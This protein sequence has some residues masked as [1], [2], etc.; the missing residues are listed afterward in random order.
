MWNCCCSVCELCF[1]SPFA[2]HPFNGSHAWFTAPCIVWLSKSQPDGF[3]RQKCKQNFFSR[4]QAHHNSNT[5][6]KF[7]PSMLLLRT[8]PYVASNPTSLNRQ[9]FVFHLRTSA[10]FVF[11]GA[12]SS[13]RALS[14]VLCLNIHSRTKTLPPISCSSIPLFSRH[15]A[16][17]L[18]ASP[19]LTCI[20][21]HVISTLKLFISPTPVFYLAQ[22]LRTARCPYSLFYPWISAVGFATAFLAWEINSEMCMPLFNTFVWIMIFIHTVASPKRTT[23]SIPCWSWTPARAR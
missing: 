11:S 5:H 14:V 17:R 12:L 23:A 6:P 18:A 8:S 1:F 16:D 3:Q 9:I 22:A 4:P 10:N 21:S 2:W 15:I 20:D 7:S 13:A 19:A